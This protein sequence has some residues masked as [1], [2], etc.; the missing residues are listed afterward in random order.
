MLNNDEKK[1]ILLDA[2]KNQCLITGPNVGV[3]PE[4]GVA[5]SSFVNFS[6]EEISAVIKIYVTILWPSYLHNGI[7]YT[8]KIFDPLFNA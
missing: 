3:P 8:D 5:K 4:M 1:Q 7:S 6:I 2:L